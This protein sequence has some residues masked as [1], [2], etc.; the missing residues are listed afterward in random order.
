MTDSQLSLV[1]RIKW[2]NSEF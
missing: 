2:K 1:H